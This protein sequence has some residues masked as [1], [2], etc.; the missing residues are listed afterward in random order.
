MVKNILVVG[1]SGYVGSQLVPV[2]AQKGYQVTATGRDLS[3]LEKRQWS[4][5]ENVTLVA[6]DLSVSSDFSHILNDIDVVYFL[7]HGMSHGH[8]FCRSGTV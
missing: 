6:L 2:L 7:V 1:A 4:N 3:L 8:D 5:L